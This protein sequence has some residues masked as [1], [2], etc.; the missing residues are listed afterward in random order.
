M[1][2][3]VLTNENK[4]FI[5]ENCLVISCSKMATLF[6]CSKSVVQ[7][8]LKSNGI[9]VPRDIRAKFKTEAMTGRTSFS[10]EEDDIIRREYIN[11]PVK[12]LV[13][14]FLP[15]RSF[16]GV[17]GRLKAMGL[18]IP[19][20]LVENRKKESRFQQGASPMNKGKKQAEFMSP[21]GIARTTNT[22]FK[23]GHL[24]HNTRTD[25]EISVRMD[26]TGI[27][28]QYIRVSLGKWEL[29]QRHVWEQHHG[30]IP[31][32]HVIAFR[33][34]NSLNCDISNLE[35]LSMAENALRNSGTINLTDTTVAHYLATKS[36]KVDLDLKAE[37]LK[38]PELIELKRNQLL[39]K[40]AIKE[41]DKIRDRRNG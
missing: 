14:K 5:R 10:Q 23:K 9:H 31:P 11:Y 26:K 32:K 4:A 29:L 22:R 30:K 19:A 34:K 17:A 33:D 18:R 21:E 12:T 36:R 6:G 37:L 28:Y 15:G 25:F 24:P 8:F 35:L 2:K 27:P 38:H 40:R 1:P 7:R 41:N 3:Q 20:E 13:D 39:L 16:T